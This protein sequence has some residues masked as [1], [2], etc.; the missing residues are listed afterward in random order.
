MSDTASLQTE[1]SRD[2]P[3]NEEQLPTV[4]FTPKLHAVHAFSR[5]Q[6]TTT[7]RPLLTP[8]YNPGNGNRANGALGPTGLIALF[9]YRQLVT[10]F[11][12]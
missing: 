2:V 12:V 7:Y 3:W 1:T 9:F 8:I 11:C 6:Q 4:T 5:A 10:L